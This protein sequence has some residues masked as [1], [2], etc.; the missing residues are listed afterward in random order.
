[1]GF[2]ASD[3]YKPAAKFL[4][5][6]IFLDDVILHYLLMVFSF[7]ANNIFSSVDRYTNAT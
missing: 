3:R 5:K 4:Y 2:W 7:Y 6:S 1:M